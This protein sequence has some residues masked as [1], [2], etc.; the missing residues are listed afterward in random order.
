MFYQCVLSIITI[1]IVLYVLLQI[2]KLS[3]SNNFEESKKNIQEIKNDILSIKKITDDNKEFY[4]SFNNQFDTEF[5]LSNEVSSLPIPGS[6]LYDISFNEFIDSKFN[7]CKIKELNNAESYIREIL[8]YCGLLDISSGI[9]IIA[10]IK[11]ISDYNQTGYNVI[12]TEQAKKMLKNDEIQF[13][14]ERLTKKTKGVLRSTK[15][16]KITKLADIAKKSKVLKQ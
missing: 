9:Q 4:Q 16:K 3:L 2:K 12:L 14:V 6:S 15:T 7:E 1:L 8:S 10:T 11:N 5:N 13:M